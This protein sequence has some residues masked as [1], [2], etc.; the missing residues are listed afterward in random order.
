VTPE[1]AR[2]RQIIEIHRG[3]VGFVGT[4]EALECLSALDAKLEAAEQRACQ[5]PAIA[6]RELERQRD[7]FRIEADRANEALIKYG[8]HLPVCASHKVVWVTAKGR[9]G[10]DCG[11]SEALAAAE[12]AGD[13]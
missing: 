2:I 7:A 11:L 4:R 5:S 1:S 12:G 9:P 10:C 3:K 8:R 13:E 6:Y